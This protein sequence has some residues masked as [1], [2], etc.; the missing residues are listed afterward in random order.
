MEDRMSNPQQTAIRIVAIRQ[1][2]ALFEYRPWRSPLNIYETEQ[3]IQLV[4][5]LAGI[6]L[7]DLH[8]QVHP[9]NVQIR[10]TRQMAPPPGLRRIQRME[11]ASG[12]FQ[13]E[14]P[15]TTPI[16]PDRAEAQY[17]NGLLEIWLPFA[18]QATQRVVVIQ[19][20]EAG[21]R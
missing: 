12:P 19:L 13:V 10:G 17:G 20:G 2:F 6:A 15:L 14:I 11:I 3:G 8:V 1:P 16:D 9:T 21:A 18:H 7:D 4:A 5:E